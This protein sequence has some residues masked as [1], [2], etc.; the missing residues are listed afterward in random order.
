MEFLNVL[1][2]AIAAFA[3][4]AV[5]YMTMSKPWMEAAKI[6]V[7]AEGKPINDGDKMPFVI[8]LIGMI[9]AAGMMRHIFGM[10]GITEMG[11]ALTA[12]LGIGLF[13]VMPWVA[14]NYAFGQRPFKLTLIDGVN[15]VAGSAIMAIVLTAF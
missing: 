3:F 13:S 12:G 1:A 7:N 14:M 15:V 8:G 4:G 9:V 6:E 2:A 5:W 10:A 11:K